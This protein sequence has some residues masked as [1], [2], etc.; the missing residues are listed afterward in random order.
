MSVTESPDPAR[1][2]VKCTLSLVTIR[3]L[4]ALSRRG[5]HGRGVSGVMTALIEQGVREAFEKGYIPL[6]EDTGD[7]S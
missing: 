7:H 4:V 6:F 1:K 2:Q 5:T 3:Y